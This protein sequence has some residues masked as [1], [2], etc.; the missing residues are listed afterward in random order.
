MS[1][2]DYS[3]YFQKTFTVEDTK[4]H[5]EFNNEH[6]PVHWDIDFVKEYSKFENVVVPG[7]M[8]QNCFVHIPDDYHK[9]IDEGFVPVLRNVEAK[10][11]DAPFVDKPVEFFGKVIKER[12]GKI[13][14]VEYEVAA[15]QGERKVATGKVKIMVKGSW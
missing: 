14:Y 15:F 6:N 4:A 12:V 8:I 2:E 5:C 7:M 11:F 10:F 1:L 9:A 3:W 13:S